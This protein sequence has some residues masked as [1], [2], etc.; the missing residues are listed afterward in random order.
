MNRLTALINWQRNVDGTQEAELVTAEVERLDSWWCA[1]NKKTWDGSAQHS[2]SSLCFNDKC[3]EASA[4]GPSSQRYRIFHPAQK[5]RSKL[6]TLL[7][8]SQVSFCQSKPVDKLYLYGCCY[9]VSWLR[10][11]HTKH[12]RK[13]RTYV[14]RSTLHNYIIAISKQDAAWLPHSRGRRLFSGGK[15][16]EVSVWRADGTL[17][18]IFIIN[19]QWVKGFRV[20]WI[21]KTREL[22]VHSPNVSSWF[23]ALNK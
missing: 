14:F 22:H 20:Q 16:T 4:R 1:H 19:T 10:P 6:Q 7:Q 13:W 8:L 3:V 12:P 11:W 9:N 17:W 21:N 5:E 18:F 15:F 23:C 2:T